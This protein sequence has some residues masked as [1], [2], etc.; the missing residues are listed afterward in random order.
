[1]KCSTTPRTLTIRQM[2]DSFYRKDTLRRC[3]GLRTRRRELSM[4]KMS[5]HYA[6]WI[7]SSKDTRRREC[8]GWTLR[9][10]PWGKV[11]PWVSATPS[12]RRSTVYRL[13]RTSYLAT[14]NVLKGRFGRR[15][16]WQATI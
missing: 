7:A 8:G 4:K 12:R 9:L 6:V 3:Y 13:T 14:E 10:D 2:I 11:F 1:M 15:R 5:P 16:H